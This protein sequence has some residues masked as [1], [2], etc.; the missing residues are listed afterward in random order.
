MVQFRSHLIHAFVEGGATCASNP[1]ATH[2]RLG[3][4]VENPRSAILCA[5]VA[6]SLLLTRA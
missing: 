6:F 2:H 5:V 4:S 3:K 1:V